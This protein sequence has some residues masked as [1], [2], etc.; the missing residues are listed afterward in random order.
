MNEEN[1]PKFSFWDKLKKIKHIEIY[2]AV[3][4]VA[5]L[6]LIYLSNF[7]NRRTSSSSSKTTANEL[8]IT[9]YVQNLEDNLEEILSNIGGVSNVKVMITL[10]MSETTI[11]N[12]QIQLQTMPPI[13]G[14]VVTAKGVEDVAVKIKVLHAIEAVID[15][16]NGNIQ[17]LST[18]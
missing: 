8:S 18:K 11:D 3:I 15:V 9:G 6:L 10:D 4:F 7:S 14:V 1:K 2:I 17:I 5:I 12:Q 16:T 13:K